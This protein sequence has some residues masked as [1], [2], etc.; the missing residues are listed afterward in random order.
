MPKKLTELNGWELTAALLEV[1]EPIGNLACD[2]VFWSTFEECTRQ[3]IGLKPKDTLRFLL[4]TYSRLFPILFGEEHKL[5]T[6]RILSVIEGEPVEKLM[7]KSGAELLK[8]C[9]KAFKEQLRPFFF[10]SEH[11]GSAE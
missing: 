9:E 5:D 4:K 6:F 7:E 1:A 2:D 10:K 8:D 11:T 3:G